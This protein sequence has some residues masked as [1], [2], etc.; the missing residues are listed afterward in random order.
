ML[1]NKV[2]SNSM[3]GLE[4]AGKSNFNTLLETHFMKNFNSVCKD[5]FNMM[6]TNQEGISTRHLEIIKT[7]E[8]TKARVFKKPKNIIKHE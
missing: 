1:N 7:L 8:K 4:K 2:Y 5:A 3:I 6:S